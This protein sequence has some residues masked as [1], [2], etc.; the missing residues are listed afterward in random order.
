MNRKNFKTHLPAV[1]AFSL[2]FSFAQNRLLA[3]GDVG[4]NLL[5]GTANVN[6][7]LYT[8]K[9]GDMSH[10][11]SLFYSASGIKVDDYDCTYGLG[12]HLSAESYVSRIVKGFPDDIY[13]YQANS[14]YK[15][16]HGWLAPSS[17]SAAVQTFTI[18]NDDNA[19]TCTDETTD[20]NNINNSFSDNF[21]TEPD[22][23]S[24]NAPG[25]NC[26]FVFGPGPQHTI[27]VYPYTDVKISYTK[28]NTSGYIL[29]FT[30]TNSNGIQYTFDR[31][32]NVS[33]FVDV[34]GP[35]GNPDI[36]PQSLDAFRRDFL[37]Y[38]K[39]WF[40][41]GVSYADRWYLTKMEDTKGNK[42]EY[43]YND[44]LTYSNYVPQT[45]NDVN[46]EIWKYASGTHSKQSLYTIK[47]VRTANQLTKIAKITPHDDFIAL[48]DEVIFTYLG[49]NAED[50]V[51]S[52]S[53]PGANVK[54]QV[55]LSYTKKFINTN[56]W[57]FGW[58][59]LKGVSFNKSDCENTASLY[60]FSYIGVDE[61][62]DYCYCLVNDSIKYYK[63]YWGYYNANYNALPKR[64]ST[65]PQV[66]VYPNNANVET[67]KIVPIPGYSGTVVPI[68]GD[69]MNAN[70][71]AE[72][73]TIKRITNPLGGVTEMEYENN[74]YFDKDVNAAV[75]GGGIRI[76]KMTVNDGL[77][78]NEITHFEYND[79]VTG[80]TSGRA[81]SVQKYAFAKPNTTSYPNITDQVLNSTFLSSFNL[82]TEQQAILYGKV[83]VK[84]SGAGKT[85]YD[86]NTSGTFGSP[87]TA[88]WQETINYV[89]RMD[90]GGQTCTPI[91][92]T[93][94]NNGKL[95]YPFS[96]QPNFDFERGLLVK[97]THYNEAATPQVVA[98]DEY[99]YTLSS[100][101][102][103]KVYGLKFDEVGNVKAY[104]KYFINT[105]VDNLITQK[106]SKVYNSNASGAFVQ[107]TENI[108]YQSAYHKEPTSIQKINSDGKTSFTSLKY[109]KDYNI[110]TLPAGSDM[111]TE[112]LYNLAQKNYNAVVET[113]S[114]IVNAGVDNITQAGLTVF[115]KFVN[116][117]AATAYNYLPKESWKFVSQ[118]G[119]TNFVN[120]A[121][122]AGVFSKHA[123]YIKEATIS[124][125]TL[126]G[127]PKVSEG[128]NR[129]ANT[130][131]IYTPGPLVI[132]EFSNAKPEH[133]GYS[134][135]DYVT[136]QAAFGSSGNFAVPGGR[137]STNCLNFQAGTTIQRNLTN[138]IHNKNIIVSFWVK[139]IPIQ[140]QSI[141]VTLTGAT[142]STAMVP[143][144]K[145]TKWKYYEVK[146]A[147][148][149]DASYT[150]TIQT[151]INCLIDDIL[152]YPDNATATHYNYSNSGS[153][154]SWVFSRHMLTAKNGLSG[155]GNYYEYDQ[156]GRLT[157]VKDQFEN[158]IEYKRYKQPNNWVTNTGVNIYWSQP[159][160]KNNPATFS[161]SLFGFCYTE[162]AQ[163][164][165]N[166]GDGT[167]PVTTT[168]I[169]TVHTYALPGQYHVKVTTVIPLVGTV[170]AET[171]PYVAGQPYTGVNVLDDFPPAPPPTTV[172]PVICS[173][174]VSQYTVATGQC[175]LA[176][177]QDL[178]STCN[179]SN[180]KL[181]EIQGGTFADIGT[182]IWETA[183]LNEEDWTY[184]GTGQTNSQVFHVVR[185][186]SYRMRCKVYP[187][188]Q[189]PGYGNTMGVSNIITVTK[190]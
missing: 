17:V 129:V 45:A 128:M 67:Y 138:A 47:Q 157:V 27:K 92:P 125:Y 58:F 170:T 120:S 143:L 18:T 189:T 95:Q 172:T 38:R 127:I 33:H 109:V 46:V 56:W 29:S 100:A 59:Y 31:R 16:I 36:T 121:S 142:V 163:F 122:A 79:P 112:A 77:N 168:D 184:A 158:I 8:V 131:I 140:Q 136:E 71:S 114:G 139:D 107:E 137:A 34:N 150:L 81:T 37:L 40:E 154:A 145:S 54:T 97:T 173:A 176:T 167:P 28:N 135:F 43:F 26:S 116:N 57:D 183:S 141:T 178:P 179:A 108:S 113:K 162:G 188:N 49:T 149:A 182:I 118:A 156:V 87:S 3:Q 60:K 90:I 169:N 55:N 69:D 7:P 166:F 4:V 186:N 2:F 25:L 146:V 171:Q 6:I 68:A 91:Q 61:A 11:I 39:K 110:A 165:W 115:D 75:K 102:S 1:F 98:S 104:G 88:N 132:A 35:N 72:A 85:V 84:K 19:A 23:F 41:T 93:V 83:T 22:E 44:N 153:A 20:A 86:Y 15:V 187:P 10:S 21:D 117:Y 62:T 73:G 152:A 9:A 105:L 42:I 99:T 160:V 53:F 174:G 147:N 70:S 80:I 65:K 32:T 14:S 185:T 76:K 151:T 52:I 12:W 111:P 180:F 66:W 48:Q 161:A 74:E 190:N 63:D 144:L 124:Q 155:I 134:N 175:I 133:T 50:P 103:D 106:I 5:T 181:I 94:L 159:V 126:N 96:S 24:I 82:N 13:D 30:A 164:T 89:A 177:C 101:Q 148:L 51:K 119:I 123:A 78:T 64:S 130:K